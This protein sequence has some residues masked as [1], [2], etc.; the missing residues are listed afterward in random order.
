MK[1]L[2]SFCA[3]F[4]LWAHIAM[5]AVNINTADQKTLETLPGI[6]VAK[7]SAI[8][9]Y[10]TENGK[11]TSVNELTRVKGIGQKLLVTIQDQI[12]VK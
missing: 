4:L 8:I 1:R 5:A 6:G 9:T 12:E 10:R 2:I 3:F 7:A 11:F